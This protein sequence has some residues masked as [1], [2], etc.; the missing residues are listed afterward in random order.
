MKKEL[1]SLCQRPVAPG[2][3]SLCAT[4]LQMEHQINY[5]IAN[6][7][8][9]IRKY[10]GGKFNETADQKAGE[11]D[12]RVNTYHP[13]SGKHTPDRRKKIRRLENANDGPK[14]RAT[15]I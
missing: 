8:Q 6:H 14:K 13:P 3:E 1:C 11:K 12:R 10:L 4:C 7:T 2:T 15:D 9:R 5:L